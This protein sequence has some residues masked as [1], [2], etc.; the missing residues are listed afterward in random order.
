MLQQEPS[1]ANDGNS[2]RRRSVDPLGIAVSIDGE[3]EGSFADRAWPRNVRVTEGYVGGNRLTACAKFGDPL[4][5]AFQFPPG[6]NLLI[7]EAATS[8]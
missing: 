8:D 6:L 4:R 3:A 7:G 2:E 5:Q 1:F